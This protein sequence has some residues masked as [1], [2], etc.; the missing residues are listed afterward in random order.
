MCSGCV[1]GMLVKSG[2]VSRLPVTVGSF[3]NAPVMYTSEESLP[4]GAACCPPRRALHFPP[5]GCHLFDAWITPSVLPAANHC[6]NPAISSEC[7]VVFPALHHLTLT[8]VT[9]PLHS[10]LFRRHLHTE[11]RSDYPIKKF[12]LHFFFMALITR[13]I[14]ISYIDLFT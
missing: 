3:S 11:V 5:P 7:K 4:T 10:R 13:M 9:R 14:M 8:D 6:E 2:V 12:L 1:V